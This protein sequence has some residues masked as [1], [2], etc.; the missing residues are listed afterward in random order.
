MER[1]KQLQRKIESVRLELDEALLRKDKFESYYEKSTE[2][3]KM[4][5][6]YIERK[7]KVN[8]C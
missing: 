6:K 2:L 3:D 8:I 4:I 1:M 7:E 5:K